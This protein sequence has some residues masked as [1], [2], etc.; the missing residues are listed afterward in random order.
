VSYPLKIKEF[1][2]YWI[3]QVVSLTGTWMQQIAQNWLVYVLTKS[4]FYLGLI[5]FLASSPMLIFSLFGGVIADRYSK[6][7]ILIVIQIF[8]IL[9]AVCLG[10]LIH[11]NLVTVWHVASASLIVGI[12]SAFDV[13]A[14]QVFITEIVSEEMITSAI[15]MQSMSFNI[16]R[17]IGP[18]L[19]GIIVTHLNFH[20]CF[21]L[22]AL[23]FLPLI[24]ILFNIK[25]VYHSANHHN[26]SM[27]Y[28]FKEGFRF[29]I[30]NKLIFYTICSVG[31]FTMFGISF[32]TILPLIAGEILKTGANG[33]GMIVSSV[34]AGSLT[35]AVIIVLKKDIKEKFRHIFRASLLF[36]VGLSGIA[37]SKNFYLTSAFAF[38]LGFAFVNFFA[39]SNS[40]IQYQTE[41]RLRGR[42]MSFFAF[43][44]L[45]F[46]P[47]GNLLTGVLAEKYGISIILQIYSFLCLTGGIIFLRILPTIR[48]RNF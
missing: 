16:A 37:F 38:L 29:L 9:P 7:N 39:V 5:S 14:R 40:F 35:G 31:I 6:R 13:P 2:A 19:A 46:T 23:S 28:F 36:P 15:A 44:F 22:N 17:V 24:I 43:V 41:Q 10:V 42:I 18:F 30:G 3:G 11:L 25:P 12:A 21:Y 8:L 27:K 4:A 20:T 48:L 34:G 33:F 1:K 47:I 32:M 45:G 26:S